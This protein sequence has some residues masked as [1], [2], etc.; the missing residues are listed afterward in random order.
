MTDS[1][2]DVDDDPVVNEYDVYMTPEQETQL[3][4]LQYINRGPKQHFSRN[5]RSHPVAMRIKEKSGFLEVDVPLDI[6]PNFNRAVGVKWGEAIRKTKDHGQKAWGFA[7][8]FER[9]HPPRA[10]PNRAGAAA[11]QPAPEE[12]D[13]TEEYLNNFDDANDK[14]HVLNKQ[15]LG[16]Q[17]LQQTATNAHYV[18][19]SF[20]GSALNHYHWLHRLYH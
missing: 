16:G 8:G 9:A 3:Y 17:I 14:G 5:D 4:L 10:I 19:G 18:V 11:A 2:I 7:G 20:R 6:N 12:E 1:P 13:H 15:T